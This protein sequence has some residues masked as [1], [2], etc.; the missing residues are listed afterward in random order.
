MLAN[1]DHGVKDGKLWVVIALGVLSSL[2]L[3]KVN[4]SWGLTFNEAYAC[5][6]TL[7]QAYALGFSRVV[8]EGDSDNIISKLQFK[9][10]PNTPLSFILDD[11]CP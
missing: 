6:F 5:F 3:S 4:A 10:R 1:L 8:V 7:Q 9:N 11:I 2:L